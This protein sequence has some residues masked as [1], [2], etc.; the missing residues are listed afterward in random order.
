MNNPK[1]TKN[2]LNNKNI[3]YHEIF[4]KKLVSNKRNSNGQN[5]LYK[6]NLLTEKNINNQKLYDIMIRE[7]KDTS[8][9][10]YETSEN[11]NNTKA[12]MITR[13]TNNSHYQNTRENFNYLEAK[14]NTSRYGNLRLENRNLVLSSENSKESCFS[15]NNYGYK[16][17]KTTSHNKKINKI[18]FNKCSQKGKIS[19]SSVSNVVARNTHN[20]KKNN[21]NIILEEYN[22]REKKDYNDISSKTEASVQQADKND[23]NK[24]NNNTNNI[25]RNANYFSILKNICLT[26]NNLPVKLNLK[27]NK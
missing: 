6:C 21:I 15:S 3:L 19:A 10:K 2:Y 12:N 17:S 13:N 20:N 25:I 1:T 7:N 16:S 27:K 23:K 14:N 18:N 22:Q 9:T 11:T 24:L 5:N 4:D 26:K 8:Y